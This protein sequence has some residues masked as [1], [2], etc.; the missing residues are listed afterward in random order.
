MFMVRLLTWSLLATA[1]IVAAPAV[2]AQP[3]TLPEASSPPPEG[4]RA[5]LVAKVVTLSRRCTLLYDQERFSEALPLA[6]EV[7]ALHRRLYPNERFPQGHLELATGLSNLGSIYR[8]LQ[9][10]VRADVFLR[11]A[12]AMNRALCPPSRFPNG[13][14]DLAASLYDLGGLH[15]ECGELDEAEPLLVEA[16]AMF[17][18]LYPPARFPDGH[19][20]VALSL[21]Y[22]G[23][24]RLS[25]G[26]LDGAESL[27]RQALDMRR[28]LY[29]AERFPDGHPHL[30][31]SLGNLGLVLCDR[32]DTGGAEPLLREALA[33]SAKVYP[34]QRFPDGHQHRAKC[35][36]NVGSLLQHQGDLIGA[37]RY[38]REALAMNE[39]LYPPELCPSGHPNLAQ[40]LNNLATCLQER[41]DLAE[42]ER[43]YRA[44]LALYRKL[45]PAERFPAGHRALALGL[46]NLGTLLRVRGEAARAEAYAREALAMYRKLYPPERYR[47][48]HPALARNLSALGLMLQARG[49]LAGAEAVVR[50]ALAIYRRQFPPSR[51]PDGHAQL[52]YCLQNLGGLLKAQGD[53]AGAEP[54]YREALA[55]CRKLYPPERFPAGHPDLA[56]TLSNQGAH[57]HARGD[58]TAAK[59]AH[60]EALTMRRRLYP[61]DLF[62]PGH[63]DLV[64]SLSNLGGVLRAGGDCAAAEPYY[65]EALV[66]QQRLADVVLADAAEAEAFNYLASQPAILNGYLSVSA[67]LPGRAAASYAAVWNGKAMVARLLERRRQALV[68]TAD[69]ATRDLGRQLQE[70]RGDLARLLVAPTLIPEQARRVQALSNRKEELERKLARQLPAF[71]ALE[72]RRRLQPADLLKH[73]PADAVFVDVLHYVRFDQD[74]EK[75]GRQGERRRRCYVAFVLARGQE[76]RRVELG[77][78]EPIEAAAAAWWRNLASGVPSPKLEAPGV[79]LG[80]RVWAPVAKHLPAGVR[81]VYLAPDGALAQVPWAALPGS[82]PGTLL[83]EDFALAVVPHG[84]FLLDA[85]APHP[86]RARRPQHQGT[87]LAV[88]DVAYDRPAKA[89]ARA[90][91]EERL[92]QAPRPGETRLTW[93]ALPGAARELERV[94][95]LAGKRPTLV[96][97]G[98]E[99][100]TAQVLLDLPKARWAHL[101]THGFFASARFLSALGVNE[102]DY[103][104]GWLGERVGSGARSP[105]VLSGLVLAGANLP[106]KDPEKEDGGI[107]TAE[108]IAG[109]NLDRMDLAVLSACETGLAR[110]ANGEGVFGLQRTF[111]IAGAKNVIASL[112][113]VDDEA[114]AALMGLF[115]HKLWHE[116]LTPLEALR[117][118]QLT[119]YRHPER[120]AALARQRGPD[121]EK[122]ARLPP[123]SATASARRAPARM[124]AGFVLSGAGR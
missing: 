27:H 74:V 46:H 112:W 16:L 8:A 32:G 55:M 83:L 91:G 53:L 65:Q 38:Y 31:G 41:G 99:A 23:G 118:A 7:L 43:Y 14:P 12:L 3:V 2:I 71:A 122:T 90:Q 119:L 117:Q 110:L 26:D 94:L 68:L 89:V 70:A 79:D 88:G 6:E 18:K 62:P 40:S 39:K 5:A 120:I 13:H 116:N 52:S 108:A 56:K 97:R 101:A 24:L 85:L 95:R 37:E 64:N 72:A 86:S 57:L 59:A 54:L 50:E 98:A 73:L 69:P 102:K 1:P 93:A 77:H 30:V 76:A 4:S 121:F 35:L 78:A 96:R 49:D 123:A 75:P 66:M 113:K 20:N 22:L 105:L 33:M 100:T 17:R 29:P 47:A 106:V 81:T 87:L 36:G 42:A 11:E 15:H 61:H 107:L 48:G 21:S 9:D 124:W 60:R 45:Y 84:P 82:K 63:P 92:G 67:G 109:L 51:Y 34:A 111:H 25:R 114:T 103:E 10:H 104:H 44:A 19:A 80:Q 115:Y 58:L 28:R